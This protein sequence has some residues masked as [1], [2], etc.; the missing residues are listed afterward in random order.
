[1][2]FAEVPPILSHS[3]QTHGHS[4][5]SACSFASLCPFCSKEIL[6]ERATAQETKGSSE[7][8]KNSSIHRDAGSVENGSSA[9][10]DWCIDVDTASRKDYLGDT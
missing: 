7:E 3:R 8:K 4:T 1:M 10:D 6:P 2:P 9:R 5:A